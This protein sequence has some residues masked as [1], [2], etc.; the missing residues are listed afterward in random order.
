MIEEKDKFAIHRNQ[1]SNW[2]NK[3]STGNEDFSVQ[4][5]IF[6]SDKDQK[7][8]EITPNFNPCGLELTPL[9]KFLAIILTS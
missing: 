5:L 8:K 2:F 6:K 3:N 7:R 9:L 4:Y 1:I